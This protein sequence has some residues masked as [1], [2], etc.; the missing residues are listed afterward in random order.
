MNFFDVRALE[1]LSIW[2]A[3]IKAKIIFSMVEHILYTDAF[4]EYE[5][6]KN[7]FIHRI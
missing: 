4:F 2:K 1:Y 7:I 6:L 3:I 5:S